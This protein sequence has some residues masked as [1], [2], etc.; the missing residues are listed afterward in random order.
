MS[1]CPCVCNVCEHACEC[2][3]EES[4]LR[5]VKAYTECVSVYKCLRCKCAGAGQSEWV[6]GK[7]RVQGHQNQVWV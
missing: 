7:G 6:E 4:E 2:G 1:V 5:S 3:E